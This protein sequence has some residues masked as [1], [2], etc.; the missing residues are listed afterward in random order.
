M[1]KFQCSAGMRFQLANSTESL[2]YI[3][4]TSFGTTFQLGLLEL[5]PAHLGQVNN[6]LCSS[7]CLV[8]DLEHL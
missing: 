1:L 2:R 3:D 5:V 7:L 6:K 8:V 4:E